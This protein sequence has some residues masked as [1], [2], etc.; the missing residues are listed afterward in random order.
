MQVR[1]HTNTSYSCIYHNI[2]YSLRA[3]ENRLILICVIL[4]E[5]VL[6]GGLTYWKFF[7]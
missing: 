1:Q 7:S 2:D 3:I 4:V 5:L 6:L